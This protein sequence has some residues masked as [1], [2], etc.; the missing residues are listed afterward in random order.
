MASLLSKFWLS[1]QA[2]GLIIPWKNCT[3]QNHFYVG[4]SSDWL[5]I[6]LLIEP[7]SM[8]SYLKHFHVLVLGTPLS[9]FSYCFTG[10]SVSLFYWFLFF[11]RSPCWNLRIPV[12][13]FST[14]FSISVAG[15]SKLVS[16]TPTFSLI[17][18]LE[19][20]ISYLVFTCMSKTVLLITSKYHW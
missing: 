4:K 15:I 7:M 16:L 19:Y 2:C 6:C 17:F 5:I 8:P 3:Y 1:K 14:I 10:P 9:L 13:L 20:V 12:Y 11:L 18:R